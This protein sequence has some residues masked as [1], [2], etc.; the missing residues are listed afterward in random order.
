MWF[1]DHIL[2][3]TPGIANG[4]W[5]GFGSDIAEF[6]IV[7]AIWHGINCHEKGCYRPGHNIN[8]TK[9]C[10]KHRKEMRDHAISSPG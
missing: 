3:A 6:A 7:G 10:H 5:G 2:G 1:I 4:L 9:V 8:G